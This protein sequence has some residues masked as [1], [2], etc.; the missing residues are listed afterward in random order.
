MAKRVETKQFG[1]AHGAGLGYAGEVVAHE[2]HNHQVFG[3]LLF[4]VKK[5][6]ALLLILHGR[7]ATPDGSL[8]GLGN[9]VMTAAG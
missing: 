7:G 4:I 8:D 2:V 6:L 5:R 3:A 9:K 1:D